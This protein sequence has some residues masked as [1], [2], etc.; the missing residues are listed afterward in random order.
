VFQEPDGQVLF[1]ECME[2]GK[3]TK[4]AI[5]IARPP[6]PAQYLNVP[7]RDLAALGLQFDP[8]PMAAFIL[9]LD[10]E[11]QSCA[12]QNTGRFLIIGDG[13][14]SIKSGMSGSPIIDSYGAAI[15]LVSTGNQTMNMHPS[16]MDCLPP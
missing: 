13:A 7:R 14:D 9:S 16:L 2:Y 1:D 4:P 15:G 12:V 3:F 5:R 10:G 8:D 6:A 11:W